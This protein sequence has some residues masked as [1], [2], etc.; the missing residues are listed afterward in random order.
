MLAIRRYFRDERELSKDDMYISSYWKIGST[1]EQH[2]KA[3][4]GAAEAIPRIG[5]S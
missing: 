3:K 1:D 4:R 5:Q 2:K